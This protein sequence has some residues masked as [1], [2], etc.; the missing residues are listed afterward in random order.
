MILRARPAPAPPSILYDV[1][2]LDRN[3]VEHAITDLDWDEAAKQWAD[4][5]HIVGDYRVRITAQ[6]G[7]G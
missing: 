7:A 6:G 5:I 1:S 2:W 4:H 3:A